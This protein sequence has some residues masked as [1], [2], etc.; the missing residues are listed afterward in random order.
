MCC[1]LWGRKESDMTWRL[2][3]KSRE[4]LLLRARPGMMQAK[5]STQE[6]SM[7]PIHR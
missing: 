2:N 5:G 4:T 6:S 1:S 7:S 3:N